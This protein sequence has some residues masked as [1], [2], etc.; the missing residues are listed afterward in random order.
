L[1]RCSARLATPNKREDNKSKGSNIKILHFHN[2]F[3]KSTP[4]SY[5]IESPTFTSQRIP[6]RAQA[7]EPE[8]QE[9]ETKS[10]KKQIKYSII[11]VA[12]SL[13]KREPPPPGDRDS[14][15]H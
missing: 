13:G 10:I 9:G 1:P 12:I 11:Y 14:I 4:S 8:Q 2:K 7:K 3:W 6:M 15:K 5:L